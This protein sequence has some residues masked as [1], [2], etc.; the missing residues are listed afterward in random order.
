MG[1]GDTGKKRPWRDQLRDFK[2]SITLHIEGVT[3]PTYNEDWNR[4]LLEGVP[5]EYIYYR[6][7]RKMKWSW[8]ELMETPTD[9]LEWLVICIAI[10]SEHEASQI[11][12]AKGG[13]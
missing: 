13:S 12:A 2:K 7:M 10:E 5:R 1:A 8:A 11:E 6:I 4:L 3:Y 9:V